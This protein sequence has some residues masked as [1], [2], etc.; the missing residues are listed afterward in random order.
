MIKKLLIANRG[1]IACRIIKTAK[2]LGIKTV[3]VCSEVDLNSSHVIAADEFV[4]LGGSTSAES[5]LD[6]KKIINAIKTS[7][8]DAVHPGYGFL[9]ENVNFSS[10]VTKAGKIFVGPP[11]K[12]ISIMGDKIAS[13]KLAFNSGVSVVPGGLEILKN[14]D[15]A[16][17]EAKRIK[18]PVIIKA[19]AGGGG[20]GMRVV[21][22]E[23]NFQEN[24]NSAIS[25]A[26]SS[27]GDSRVFVEKFVEEPRHIEIQVFGDKFGNIIHLG[28]RECSIQ[29][30]HQK[31]IE[32]APSK[33]V[34]EN[35]RKKMAKQSIKLAKAVNYY[36]AG[37]VEFVVDKNKQFYF[38]E[39]NTRLQV[40]HPVTELITKIDLVELMI[41]AAAGEKLSIKQ[42]D[43]KFSGWAI[44]SR[45][46]A[47]DSAR[48]F[49]PSIGR[50][51]RY[52]E[53]KSKS[54]RVDSGVVEGSE[55]SMY[56]DP[57]I[58]KLCV[59]S[60]TRSDA[61]INMINALDRY[62]VNGVQTNKH[63]LSN[64]FQHKDFKSGNFTTKFI[65]ENYINGFD[66]RKS[67]IINFD[68][69][70]A[71]ATFVHFKYM[72]RASSISNQVKGF[73][74]RIGSKW[75]VIVNDK[76][77]I[78]EINYNNYNQNFDIF[79]N[80]KYI[81]FKSDWKIGFPLLSALIDN[82]VLYFEINRE[83]P[84]YSI[85]HKSSII[86]VN[87]L[88]DRHAE[89]NAIMVPRKKPDTSKF[90]LSP[91]PGLLSSIFVK[92][93]QKVQEGESLVIIEAMK[94]ENIIKAEKDVI[95]KEIFCKEKDSLLVDQSIIEFE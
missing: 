28:E 57:M 78:T 14:K 86:D 72:M 79:V 58:S 46:Y 38:L 30:R 62:L 42:D 32:E 50:L 44:E 71:V 6:I 48:K 76:T 33:F 24:Y 15:E 64:I 91:M 26:K 60:N 43:V 94:M 63:F 7:N 67:K 18:F 20:K 21:Y 55:I 17:K 93:G 47:E 13:K 77:V 87:V 36:S 34:D 95:I 5:Y 74:R 70:M 75:N 82:N 84:R 25:E 59:F 11:D 37:T 19:S 61:I 56:Y 39:M 80:K 27:F 92:K 9:S 23:S 3:A 51:T 89:L 68:E 85:S 16:L 81:K 8:A 69:M 22:D 40:E 4:N 52:I 83:G 10:E 66:S 90:L 65:E 49:L 45:I 73:T 29:R 54:I 41:K 31:V 88:S 35:L 12:A 2:R 1:E 53:P